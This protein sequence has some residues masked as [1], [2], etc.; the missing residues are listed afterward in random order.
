MTDFLKQDFVIEKIEL[1]TLV[2][3]GKAAIV[4][5]NRKNHGLALFVGGEGVIQFETKK[6][7]M[8][9]EKSPSVSLGL[10]RFKLVHQN[11]CV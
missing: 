3:A 6:I 9:K 5:K 1:A 10:L 8:E 7:K 4:H 2:E 11:A